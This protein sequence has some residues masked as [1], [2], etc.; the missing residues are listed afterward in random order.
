MFGDFLGSCENHRILSQTVEA[1]FWATL[2]EK[3]GYFLFQRLVTL[4]EIS[5]MRQVNAC[6]FNSRYC[7]AIL[8][9][10]RIF[11]VMEQR[12]LFL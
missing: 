12:I 10:T 9:N 11:I 5:R 1:T 2:G 8:L 7:D 6:V 4:L 3:L